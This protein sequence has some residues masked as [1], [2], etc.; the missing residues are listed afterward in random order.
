M[1][2]TWKGTFSTRMYWP[3]GSIPAPK[4]FSRTFWPMTATAAALCS[5]ASVKKLPWT[6]GQLKISEK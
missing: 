6:T 4:S 1:P 2:T 3:M 5:S